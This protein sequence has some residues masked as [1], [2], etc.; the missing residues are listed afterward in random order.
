MAQAGADEHQGGIA[1][2]EGS[3]NPGTPSNFA[4]E[5]FND[6]VRADPCP[7]PG[8]EIAEDV[9]YTY[10]NLSQATG[11]TVENGINTGRVAGNHTVI[12][13]YGTT[14]LAATIFSYL[15]LFGGYRGRLRYHFSF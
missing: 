15:H 11:C 6:V 14:V 9:K 13:D 12:G 5:A 1:V 10:D 3:H 4:V 7:V 2:G 8:G